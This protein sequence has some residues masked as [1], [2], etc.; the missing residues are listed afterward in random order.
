MQFFSKN[1]YLL[2]KILLSFYNFILKGRFE[3]LSLSGSF[4]P[5]EVG[6]MSSREGGMT[7]ALSSPDGRVVGGLLGGLLT[8]AGPVQVPICFLANYLL[9]YL[10]ETLVIK[11]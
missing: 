11:H 7:I 5:G 1:F 3:I 4:T 10:F 9:Y 2:N 6:G 8:A